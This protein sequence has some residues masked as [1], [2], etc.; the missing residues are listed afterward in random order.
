KVDPAD[1]LYFEREIRPLL[2]NPL[3][4]WVG[5]IDDARKNDFIGNARALLFPIDWPEP[6]GLVMIEAF[7]C[8]TPVIAYDHG[9]V[10]EVVTHGRTGFIVQ[11]QQEAIEAARRIDAIDR[12]Q[13][14]RAFEERF[15]SA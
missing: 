3:M 7:A 6:F 12:W 14:R 2:D 15:T 13:C 8:G 10:P 11:N 9:S 4:E 5:E 1:Q